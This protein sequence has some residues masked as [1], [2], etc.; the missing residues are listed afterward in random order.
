MERN[1][2][3]EKD[4]P[5]DAL[6]QPPWGW[7]E[8]SNEDGWGL[9]VADPAKLQFKAERR[10]WREGCLRAGAMT[11]RRR[12]VACRM[13]IREAVSVTEKQRDSTQRH[14]V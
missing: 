9:G 6:A 12:A 13:G 11:A 4:G 3:A 8:A 10:G 1:A 7:K 2:G 14:I 5:E